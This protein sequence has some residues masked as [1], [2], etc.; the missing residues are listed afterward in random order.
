MSK[1]K[2]T[3]T[4]LKAANGK[5]KSISYLTP[6]MFWAK[7]DKRGPNDCWPYLGSRNPDG[8]G[9]V[10]FN[11]KHTKSHRLAFVLSG[12][13]IQE[14][15]CVCHSCDN[16]PCCNPSHLRSATN[17]ENLKERDLKRR[18]AGTRRTHCPKGH[19]YTTQNTRFDKHNKRH[20]KVCEHIRNISI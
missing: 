7:V 18:H 13:V 8:Y 17:R 20:C 4:E 6:A 2:P 10:M 16:P 11:G 3:E 5:W 1:V 19:K 15:H 12:G 9:R 14:G